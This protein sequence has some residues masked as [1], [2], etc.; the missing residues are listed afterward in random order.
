MKFGSSWIV[1]APCK[2]NG[3]ECPERKSGCRDSCERWAAYEKKFKAF[4]EN[5]PNITK[6]IIAQ[7]ISSVMDADKIIVM[8]D[9]K[10]SAMLS[11]H[12]V[13]IFTVPQMTAELL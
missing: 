1:K 11:A 8:D 12:P 13:K 4:K 9:G 3:V 10:I 7:R 6:I 2:V 5:I